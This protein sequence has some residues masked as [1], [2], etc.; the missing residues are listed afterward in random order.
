MATEIQGYYEDGTTVVSFDEDYI[1]DTTLTDSGDVVEGWVAETHFGCLDCVDLSGPRFASGV[2]G[3][4][5]LFEAS[6]QREF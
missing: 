1:I 6:A 2:S 5:K 3:I 4:L